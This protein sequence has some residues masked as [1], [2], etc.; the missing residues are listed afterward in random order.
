MQSPNGEV[1]TRFSLIPQQDVTRVQQTVT[2]HPHGWMRWVWPLVRGL[3][4]K[5]MVSRLRLLKERVENDGDR[6]PV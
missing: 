5:K 4:R 2:I 3:F 1:E 6:L